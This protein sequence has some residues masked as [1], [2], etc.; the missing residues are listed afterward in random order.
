[1]KEVNPVLRSVQVA[2]VYAAGADNFRISRY[3][4][5]AKAPFDMI[6]PRPSAEVL[7]RFDDANLKGVTAHEK[8][9]LFDFGDMRVFSQ[10]IEEEHL[11]GRI[12]EFFK[13][14][15]KDLV[16]L[17]DAL[18]G[19]ITRA[20]IATEQEL[21][22]EVDVTI[23]PKGKSI[24][25][26]SVSGHFG[27]IEE[28]YDVTVHKSLPKVSFRVDPVH[29]YEVLKRSA[30]LGYLAETDPVYFKSGKS[31]HLIQTIA[32]KK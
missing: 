11:L 31:E 2:G 10:V 14:R 23:N 30:K 18:L 13:G 26:K 5:K 21:E 1:M 19:A 25:C 20:K 32:K 17:P 6:L 22:R 16:D 12:N 27:E 24:V 7:S 8:G 4:L 9:L 29:F 15:S 28:T 3:K